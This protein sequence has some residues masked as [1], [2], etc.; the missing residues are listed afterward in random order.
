MLTL[1]Q[2]KTDTDILKAVYTW[3]ESAHTNLEWTLTALKDTVNQLRV[4]NCTFYQNLDHLLEEE[5]Q[6]IEAYLERHQKVNVTLKQ[7][8]SMP[9]TQSASCYTFSHYNKW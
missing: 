5:P 8:L 1:A 3:N 2:H 4:V 7:A 9:S 6:R